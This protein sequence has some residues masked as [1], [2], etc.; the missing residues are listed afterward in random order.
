MR[1]IE[2]LGDRSFR[3]PGREGESSPAMST[4]PAT[5]GPGWRSAERAAPR[6]RALPPQR[7]RARRGRPAGVGP[8]EIAVSLGAPWIEPEDVEAFIHEV[9][10]GRARVWHLPSA[11]YWKIVPLGKE[12]AGRFGTGSA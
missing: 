1:A 11:A 7:R 12:P 5:C 9:L 2:V 6:R 10:G 3:D 8:L 4:S